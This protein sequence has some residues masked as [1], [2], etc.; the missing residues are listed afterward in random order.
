[1]QDNVIHIK[2]R[3]SI[4]NP[5]LKTR[6]EAGASQY[7]EKPTETVSAIEQIICTYLVEVVRRSAEKL[8]RRVGSSITGE[9][10][11]NG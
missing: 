8:A 6:L 2:S 11:S 7:T 3:F 1:M 10:V 4:F 9:R 5:E